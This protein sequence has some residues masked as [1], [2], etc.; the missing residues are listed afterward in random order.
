VILE[1]IRMSVDRDGV[2]ILRGEEGSPLPWPRLTLAGWRRT[3]DRALRGAAGEV[4]TLAVELRRTPERL[5]TWLTVECPN[6]RMT[7]PLAR[8]SP[9]DVTR[10]IRAALGH[11]R[12]RARPQARRGDTGRVT[13]APYAAAQL[14]AVRSTEQSV[15]PGSARIDAD[16][17]VDHFE[18]LG[19]RGDGWTT[20]ANGN[21]GRVA[22]EVDWPTVRHAIAHREHRGRRRASYVFDDRVFSAPALVLGVR[23]WRAP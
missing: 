20:L 12:I 22:L 7:V 15:G 21:L 8:P 23:A 9:Q 3:L 18:E 6:W 2:D 11:A 17:V 10:P 13:L 4:A 16:L 14:F 5:D 19:A 1:R